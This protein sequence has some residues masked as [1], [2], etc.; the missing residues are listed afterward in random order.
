[1]CACMCMVSV[2]YM[3]VTGPESSDG[4]FQILLRR[5]LLWFRISIAI[6]R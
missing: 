2:E 4:D 6:A 5:R 1:M 3:P